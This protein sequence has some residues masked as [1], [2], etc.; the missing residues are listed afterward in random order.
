MP[1]L[2]AVVGGPYAL[3][4]GHQIQLDAHG[5]SNVP[6]ALQFAW[7]FN[8]DGAYDDA[9]GPTPTFDAGAR[10]A[11]QFNVSVRVTDSAGKSVTD[12]TTLRIAPTIVYV[13]AAAATG[14]PSGTSWGDARADL[15]AVLT[16]ALPGQ[17]IRVAK[18]TYKPTDR[19]DRF[20]TFQLV[21]GVTILGGY[22]GQSAP[23][24]DA[25]DVA[26]NPTIL[27]GQI[28]NQ[29][30]DSDNSYHVVTANGADA[31]TVL[32]GFTITDGNASDRYANARGG[33]IY[34]RTGSPTLRNC[35]FTANHAVEGG[36]MGNTDSAAPALVNCTFVGNTADFNGGAIAD[37]NAAP[38]LT[39]CT[40]VRNSAKQGGAVYNDSSAPRIVNCRFDGNSSAP[41]NGGAVLNYYSPA[42]VIGCAFAG[43]YARVGGAIYNSSSA[44]AITNCTFAGN[45]AEIYGGAFYTYA[46]APT[47]TNCILWGNSAR[48]GPQIYRADETM[49]VIRYSDLQGGLTG[50]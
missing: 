14:A 25:R 5:S 21:S 48:T 6:G 2:T 13:D 45:S 36:G 8:G 18:G 22:A 4:Q 43:N 37:F 27:S 38:T 50:T 30:D 15:A 47:L 26:A 44:S 28:G 29:A 3:L 24:P 7:D 23:N 11:S 19:T 16:L 1:A 39:G 20:A 12:T 10:P 40:F 9:T 41:G 46:N 49:P 33:G 31:S 34:I 35:T 17:Q 32:D 42:A